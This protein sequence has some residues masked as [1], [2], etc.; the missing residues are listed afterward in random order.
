MNINDNFTSNSCGNNVLTEYYYNK[1]RRHL[2]GDYFPPKNSEDLIGFVAGGEEEDN[3]PQLLDYLFTDG[4]FGSEIGDKVPVA[5]CVAP[6]PVL[7]E[8]PEAPPPL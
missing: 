4:T 3:G 5:I 6:P 8:P 1:V 7:A 2:K